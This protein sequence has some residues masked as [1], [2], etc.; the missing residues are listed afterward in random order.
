MTLPSLPAPGGREFVG[1]VRE[2]SALR[3]ARTETA[4]DSRRVLLIAGEAGVGKSRLLSEAA[5]EARA[6]GWQVLLGHAYDSEGM[7]PYLPFI[8][9]LGDY[10]RACPE[11]ALREQTGAGGAQLARLV[12]VLRQR[13]PDLPAGDSLDTAGERYRLFEAVSDFLL[14]AAD[15]APA[16]LILMLDDLHWA[17][18]ST[19][20]LLEHVAR[21]PVRSSLLLVAS[22]RDDEASAASP[23]GRTLEQLARMRVSQ[24]LD[25]RRL[26]PAEVADLLATLG[27]PDPPRALVEAVYRETEGNAFF[28]QEVFEHLQ[29]EGR[30]F[31]SAGAWRRTIELDEASVPRSVRLVLE[32]R[33]DRLSEESRR[34]LTVAAVLGRVFEFDLLRVLSDVPEDA[35]LEALETAERAG[36]LTADARGQVTFAH[37]LIRQTLLGSLSQ[38][39]L[40]RLHLRAAEAIEAVHAADIGSFVSELAGHLRRA[41]PAGGDEKAFEYTMRAAETA[42]EAFAWEEA[43]RHYEWCLGVHQAGHA[44]ADTDEA[45]LLAALGRAR[46]FAGQHE[47]AR[48]VLTAAAGLFRQ[49]GDWSGSARATLLALR[50]STPVL[51]GGEL[52]EPALNAPGQRDARLEALLLL[53]RA[54]LS[55]RN[56]LDAASDA[57]QAEMLV[58]AAAFPEV[59]AAGAMHRGLA[60]EWSRRFAEAEPHFRE[61]VDRFLA[62]GDIEQAGRARLRVA[63][64]FIPAGPID[65][66]A[67]ALSEMAAHGE[68]YG[69]AFAVEGGYPLWASMLIRR[70]D[71]DAAAELLQRLPD[72]SR[73]ANFWRFWLAELRGDSA[74]VDLLMG[75]MRAPQAIPLLQMTTIGSTCRVL[76]NAGRTS[77]A[78]AL[79][80]AWAEVARRT[81]GDDVVHLWNA[82]CA[83][84]AALEFADAELLRYLYDH[85]TGYDAYKTYVL[86]SMDEMRGCLALK[87]GLHAEAR[88]WFERGLEWTRHERCVIDE[89]LCLQGLGDLALQDGRRSEAR[90]LFSEAAAVFEQYGA[91]L[92]LNRAAIRLA[93][94]GGAAPPASAAAYPAGLSEREVEVLRLLAQGKGN[95]QIA[96]ELVISLNT[97]RRHVSNI[98]DK[99]GSSNRTEAGVYAHRNNLV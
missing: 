7:P 30:L 19:L 16:G 82:M 20:L 36:L 67:V 77:E 34:I 27:R 29:D 64:C 95:Q 98:L 21:Q 44:P 38:L 33:L 57:E 75:D 53:Q 50:G 99:I 87:L 24:R 2:L 52:I 78:R 40:R 74:R 8:E 70:G 76:L 93:V 4:G 5:A 59:E 55:G 22:F 51:E 84:S 86:G 61:A 17:D 28:V 63:H 80:P 10:I 69:Q 96:D 39:R 72:T 13:L 48:E 94:L 81:V 18:E 9:A 43:V 46:T 15:A 71:F 41:G 23:L 92:Y 35:A 14:A 47:A 85:Y 62:L 37:E 79:F 89:G 3:Q 31:D 25:L 12:P 49:R 26:D 1:R 65:D 91:V 11:D 56:S 42:A 66:A 90:R 60:L 54:D 68:R 73:H 83:E 6:A 97:V 45:L 32:R 58:D 88:Q